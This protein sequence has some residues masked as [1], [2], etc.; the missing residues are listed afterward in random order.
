MLGGGF[1][2]CRS[3]DDGG[4]LGG[5]PPLTLGALWPMAPPWP[6]FAA[7]TLTAVVGT[8]PMGGDDRGGVA[9]GGRDASTGGGVATNAA[10]SADSTAV[11]ELGPLSSNRP[12]DILC[13]N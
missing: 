2:N 1:R 8:L 3:L 11:P 4:G 10:V 5:K 9:L 7:V 12:S 6:G 13:V